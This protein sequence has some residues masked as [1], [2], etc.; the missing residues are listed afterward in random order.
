MKKRY[1]MILMIVSVIFAATGIVKAVDV[2]VP[3]V[4]VSGTPAKASEVNANFETLADAVND[5]ADAS[6][7]VELETLLN[8]KLDSTGGTM[9]G[10]LTVPRLA[11]S[12]ARTHRVTVSGD[13]FRPRLSTDAYSSGFGNGGARITTADSTGSMMAQANLPDGAVITSI[14]YHIYDND[15][16]N[17]LKMNTYVQNFSA[18]YLPLHTNTVIASTGASATV[19]SFSVTPSANQTVNNNGQALVIFAYPLTNNSS[20]WS[21]NLLIRG[22]TFTYTLNEAP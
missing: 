3:H 15:P 4:F 6:D 20:K 9:T 18:S 21:A 1:S 17:D 12:T 14:T 8:N 11:Y 5:K 2:I 7:V 10:D 22:V 16:T 13:L 19:Q